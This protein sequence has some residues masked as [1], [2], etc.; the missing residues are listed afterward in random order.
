MADVCLLVEGTYPYFVGGVSTWV[1]GLMTGLPDLTFSVVHLHDGDRCQPPAYSL[2][3]N[4]LAVTDLAL[5]PERLGLAASTLDAV[6]DAAVYHA[7]STGLAGAA[8]CRLKAARPRP[9]LVTEH[10]VAWH[11]AGLGSGQLESGRRPPAGGRR[12]AP[13]EGRRRWQAGVAG[14]AKEVYA[15]ADALTTV[16]AANARLQRRMAGPDIRPVVIP[17][18]VP[19]A[20][21]V[22]GREDRGDGGPSV[23]LVGRV[24]PL[25]DVLT[26]LRACRL[27]AAERPETSFVVIGPLDH[28]PDYAGRAREEALALGL[29]DRVR[30]TGQAD[31][32]HWYPRLDV[33]V[34]TSVSEAQPLALLEAMAAGV[35]VVSTAVGGCP[36]LVRP[37]PAGSAA[38]LLTP[39]AS[40]S[41]TAAAVLVLLADPARRARMGEA[42]SARSRARHAPA[43]ML[44]A[45]RSLYSR[46][47]DPAA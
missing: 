4:C 33:V 22:D 24:V 47:A 3:P 8:G 45:Y 43:H 29:G 21:P 34:L 27:V 2:P 16:C 11:E 7:L 18:S 46:L 17:N 28:D 13:Q 40:P 10:G 9:L 31:A 6:P 19:A 42:G 5:D 20:P 23:A 30:F 32:G 12:E 38:G 15:S 36:E 39:V 44:T 26:F 14:V 25:K 35:P 41:A 37:G 1:Q